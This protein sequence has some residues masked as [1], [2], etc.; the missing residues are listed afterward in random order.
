MNVVNQDMNMDAID[1]LL[2][3]GFRII[4]HN[5]SIGGNFNNGKYVIFRPSY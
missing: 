3:F 1:S 2:C 4:K 5:D